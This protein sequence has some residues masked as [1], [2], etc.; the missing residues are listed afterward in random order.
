MELDQWAPKEARIEST[1]A[2]PDARSADGAVARP[3]G[4]TLPQLC[5]LLSRKLML[6]EPEEVVRRAFRAFDEDAKGFVSL[7]DLERAMHNVA[8]QLPRETVALAFRELDAD[9]DGRVVRAR[10][11]HATA[12]AAPQ[13]ATA[14]RATDRHRA[15]AR[16]AAW[17]AYG[18]FCH[19]F[20]ARPDGRSATSPAAPPALAPARVAAPSV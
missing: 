9:A 1:D 2:P 12:A 5:E 4:V 20:L 7:R 15:R 19:M 17:Q 11:S 13:I 16:R 18:D 6:Q 10:G 14:R 8:P 3:P